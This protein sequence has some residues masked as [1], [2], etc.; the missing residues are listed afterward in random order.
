MS[1][2]PISIDEQLSALSDGE[3]D[4]GPARFLL[5][6]VEND[7]EL[8]KR[9][10]RYQL[11]RTCLRRELKGFDSEAFCAGVM[12]RIEEEEAVPAATV[13]ARY[14]WLKR[15]VGGAIA[16]GVAG[17]VLFASS[18]QAP[19]PAPEVAMQTM[20]QPPAD[21]GLRFNLAAQPVSERIVQTIDPRF[22]A[23]LVNHSGAV[24]TV[25]RRGTLPYAYAV[26]LRTR[27]EADGPA[28]MQESDPNVRPAAAVGAQGQ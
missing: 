14:P 28:T 9:F 17:L 16:A 3:L 24:A 25:G 13:A 8:A 26:G 10:E 19:A 20:S 1:Q 23:Y 21:T 7:A 12:A 6:R 2:P 5:R 4:K 22:E 27:P 15:A 11:M 18:V